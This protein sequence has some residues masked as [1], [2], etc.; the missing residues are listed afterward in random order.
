[1]NNEIIEIKGLQY[2]ISFIKEGGN[3][4]ES[5]SYHL[6]LRPYKHK[7]NILVVKDFACYTQG[8]SQGTNP[9][10]CQWFLQ[11]IQYGGA[12]NGS[13]H[14]TP[15]TPYMTTGHYNFIKEVALGNHYSGFQ[16]NFNEFEYGTN[17]QNIKSQMIYK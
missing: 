11:V 15:G 17:I 13:G 3:K 16:F 6:V 12:S 9:S 8:Y 1:M 2:K 5:P 7:G 4:H 14:N 10:G